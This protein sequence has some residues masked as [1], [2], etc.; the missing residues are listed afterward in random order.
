M[1]PQYNAS[2]FLTI[3]ISAIIIIFPCASLSAKKASLALKTPHK[4]EIH[5]NASPVKADSISF[6]SLK[7]KIYFSGFDK[8]A[9]S[10]KESFLITN[11]SS[12]TIVGL[13]LRISYFD[14]Q[15]RMLHARDI[16]I[17]DITVPPGETR[18][19]TIKSFD[20][21]G[22]LYHVNSKHPKSGAQP[23]TVSISILSILL[24]R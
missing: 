12:R 5:P 1:I 15:G 17:E 23:F 14:L 8:P 24:P 6:I 9:T 22:T 4:K 18:Q 21:S 20:E 2:N 3:L 7:D 13:N 10:R 16:T 11:E 19:K